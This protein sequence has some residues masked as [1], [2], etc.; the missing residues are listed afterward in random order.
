MLVRRRNF[1][2][3]NLLR[4]GQAIQ[5]HLALG[6]TPG[7]HFVHRVRVTE[8]TFDDCPREDA[9]EKILDT[10]VRLVGEILVQRFDEPLAVP[11]NEVC[12][13]HL[14]N[15]G[16]LDVPLINVAVSFHGR[17]LHV[18]FVPGW[19][20]DAERATRPVRLLDEYAESNRARFDSM[21]LVHGIE[22][23]GNLVG[24]LLAQE[25]Q[26]FLGALQRVVGESAEDMWDPDAHS[27]AVLY[28]VLVNAQDPIRPLVRYLAF[29]IACPHVCL[30]GPT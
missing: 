24:E 18:Q 14:R 8:C 19:R 3:A 30:P 25:L 27:L 28:A 5:V 4:I 2:F 6:A 21:F 29:L 13:L 20:V 9:A 23:A 11:G 17:W 1:L 15:S 12:Q 10:H 16:W 26:V 7:L 22:Q